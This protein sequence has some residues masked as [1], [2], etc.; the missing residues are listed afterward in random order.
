MRSLNTIYTTDDELQDFI[1]RN[2]LYENVFVQIFTGVLNKTKILNIINLLKQAI[3]DVKIIGSSTDGEIIDGIV[4]QHKIVINFNIFENTVV[5][6]LLIESESDSFVLGEK[7]AKTLCDEKTKLLITFADGLHVNGEDFI[8]GINAVTNIPIAGGLAGDNAL[9]EETFVFN[10]HSITSCGCVGAVFKSDVL[11][12]NTQYGFNWE[13]IGRMMKVTKSH[14][15]VVY[16]IDGQSPVELYRHYFGDEIADNIVK[17][18]IEFPLII[19]KDNLQIARAV[20]GQN[21]D[22]SLIFAGNVNTGD[23]VQFGYGNIESILQKDNYLL[24]NIAK[25]DIESIFIYSCMARRR[26]LADKVEYEI[27]PFSH[28]ASV[29]GFFTYGEFFSFNRKNVFF[30]QTMTVLV[31][32]E[33]EAKKEF[34]YHVN[35]QSDTQLVTLK[36]LTN[37]VHVTTEELMQFNTLLEQKVKEKTVQLKAKNKELEYMYYHDNLTALPN[38]YALDRDL[39]N[40]QITYEA[41]LIDIKEFSKINDLYGECVGDNILKHFANI[42]RGLILE[43]E[44]KIYRVGADQFIIVNLHDQTNNLRAIA[45]DILNII[46]SQPLSIKVKTSSQDKIAINIDVRVAYVPKCKDIKVKLDLSLNYAKKNNLD[47]IEYSPQLKLEEKLEEELQTVNRVKMALEEDR[48]IPVFQKIVK[49]DSTSYECLVRMREGD[50]LISPF[51]FLKAVEHTKYYFDITKTMIEKSF[52]IFSHRTETIS[53]NFSYKDLENQEIV[54]FLI[55]KIKHYNMQNRVIIELLESEALR[56]FNDIVRFIE[57]VKQY[58]VKIAIDDFGSGYSNFIY[59]ANIKP[60]FIKID[61]SLIKNID[62]NHDSLIIT[63]HINDFAKELGCKT[64]AEFVHNQEVYNIVKDM[65]V[66]GIQGYFIEE[67]KEIVGE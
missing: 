26:F 40:S 44:Y 55:E 60:D 13:G 24:E 8:N 7:L 64:V 5:E 61:G 6:T 10:E 11:R 22:G 54:N 45:Q 29:S 41:L 49:K 65:G 43:Y 66:D 25:H 52:K 67:P 47:Y 62:H 48:I 56:D 18:G 31:L 59:L 51:F 32:S 35:Y 12:L 15:N 23:V 46:K 30:N 17:V 1:I 58:G 34:K 4:T 37:L 36:A 21:E 39:K 57:K 28:I 20:V 2:N 3:P 38:R 63:K 42:L 16:E 19:Q 14:K 50:K 53:I 27:Q 9:F 33:T